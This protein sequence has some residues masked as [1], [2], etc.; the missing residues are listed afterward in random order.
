MEE[1]HSWLYLAEKEFSK[2]RIYKRMR[3][4]ELPQLTLHSLYR[5][6]TV[7]DL[8]RLLHCSRSMLYSV[9]EFLEAEE[10]TLLE[11]DSIRMSHERTLSLLKTAKNL[12]Y[13]K[14]CCFNVQVVKIMPYIPTTLRVLK[15]QWVEESIV[16]KFGFW[17]D[18]M[19]YRDS[20]KKLSLRV[21]RRS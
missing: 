13:L 5:Y 16:L 1:T 14:L 2:L 15:L 21:I 12:N 10:V 6:L 19:V 7:T 8:C 9:R 17:K 20:L 18:L 3:L 11:N 4:D